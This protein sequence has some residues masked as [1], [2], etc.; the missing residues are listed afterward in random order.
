MPP[1]PLLIASLGNPGPRYANTLHSAGHILLSAL[2]THLHHPPFAPSSRLLAH[3]L[4]SRAS[5]PPYTLWQSPAYMNASGPQLA[6]AFRN[7]LASLPPGTSAAGGDG[8]GSDKGRGRVEAKLVILHDELE[9]PLGRLKVRVG[10]ASARGHRGVRSCV[11]ALRGVKGGEEGRVVRVGVGVGRC[12]GR[13]REEVAGWLLR[14]MEGWEG[15]VLRGRAA[16]L[17]GMLGGI[18]EGRLGG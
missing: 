2:A 6:L 11:E 13:G 1:H 18:A 3:A 7:W 4:V 9:A 15:R 16:E 17:E 10:G 5:S 8:E 14:E 12:E